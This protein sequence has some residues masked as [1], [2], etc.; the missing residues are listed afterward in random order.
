MAMAEDKLAMA[1]DKFHFQRHIF[2]YNHK[3]EMVWSQ[4][5]ILFK[6]GPV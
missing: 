2:C 6:M 1:E 3:H 4:I 5:S